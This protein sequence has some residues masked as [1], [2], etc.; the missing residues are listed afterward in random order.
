[1]LLSWF[2]NIVYYM[3]LNTVY[4][5]NI[6]MPILSNELMKDFYPKNFMV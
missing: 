4:V 1:M 6:I 5:Y 3:F 2:T